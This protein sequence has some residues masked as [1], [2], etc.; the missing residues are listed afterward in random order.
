MHQLFPVSTKYNAEEYGY[1][2][3]PLTIDWE[4]GKKY[5]YSLEFCGTNSGA[6]VY[7]PKPGDGFPTDNVV[8]APADKEGHNVLTDPIKF[9]VSVSG[10]T[11]AE[12]IPNMN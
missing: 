12:N 7:P 5:I 9:S 2:C 11:E 10:W 8:E 3:V 1:T 4:P 6:G